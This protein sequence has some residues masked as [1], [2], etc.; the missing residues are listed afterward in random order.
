MNEVV[1]SYLITIVSGDDLG[2]SN[3]LHPPNDSEAADSRIGSLG[4]SALNQ[5]LPFHL[6]GEGSPGIAGSASLKDWF[7]LAPC[8]GASRIERANLSL[9]TCSTTSTFGQRDNSNVLGFGDKFE[10]KEEKCG[11][12]GAEDN[13]EGM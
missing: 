1:I 9:P 12:P 5:G 10:V 2:C 8:D 6:G 7:S 11:N 4:D 3:T 13:N